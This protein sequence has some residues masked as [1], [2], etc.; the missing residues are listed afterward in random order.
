MIMRDI[1][2][3]YFYNRLSRRAQSQ[4]LLQTQLGSLSRQQGGS[5][6]VCD[7]LVLLLLNTSTVWKLANIISWSSI[8]DYRSVLNF[9]CWFLLKCRSFIVLAFW[10]SVW[11]SGGTP[12]DRMDSW[13]KLASSPSCSRNGHTPLQHSR[14]LNYPIWWLKR[15]CFYP[16]SYWANV[17][18]QRLGAFME[19]IMG[20]AITLGG[21]Y[22]LSQLNLIWIK[23]R[24]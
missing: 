18:L 4:L 11:L 5:P 6:N 19:W 12:C 20:A 15:L 22:Q 23:H 7:M 8:H 1:L 2:T 9:K 14:Y 16:E 21:K 13:N 24:P 10:I 17:P 3:I